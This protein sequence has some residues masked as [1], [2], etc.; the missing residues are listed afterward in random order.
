MLEIKK[1]ISWKISKLG[2]WPK[3]ELGDLGA[4]QNFLSSKEGRRRRRV[5]DKRRVEKNKWLKNTQ[6]PWRPR[7]LTYYSM[8]ARVCATLYV[9]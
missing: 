8:C 2:M 9:R 1:T 4:V 6:L 5:M 7:K 3:T